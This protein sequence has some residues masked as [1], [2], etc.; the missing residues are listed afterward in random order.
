MN[1]IYDYFLYLDASDKYVNM[2]ILISLK[3]HLVLRFDHR[4]TIQQKRLTEDTISV[5]IKSKNC[6]PITEKIF[7]L[8]Y[9]KI[10]TL[11]IHDVFY[12]IIKKDILLQFEIFEQVI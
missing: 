11:S 1:T 3:D 2:I 7:N 10:K 6:H 5:L 12:S 4:I 8:Y 9:N